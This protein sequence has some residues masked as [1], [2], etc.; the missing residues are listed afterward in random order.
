MPCSIAPPN[1]LRAHRGPAAHPDP[2]QP[3][4][5]LAGWA[6][7]VS[8]MPKV[9]P[10]RPELS[11]QP[12]PFSS[13]RIEQPCPD[14]YPPQPPSLASRC[15]GRGHLP[16]VILPVSLERCTVHRRPVL[17]LK[18]FTT[19]IPGIFR[20]S[21]PSSVTIVSTPCSSMQAAIRA[22]QNLAR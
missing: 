21:D 16:L 11:D 20:K 14:R 12:L 3:P 4:V 22:S 17:G 19:V 13:R 6:M 7:R 5:L 10:G 15:S 2:R 9:L 8:A 18:G 1:P